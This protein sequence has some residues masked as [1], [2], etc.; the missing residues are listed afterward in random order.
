L[1]ARVGEIIMNFEINGKGAPATLISGIASDISTWSMQA[2][3]FA[4][5]FLTIRF[6]NRG[7]GKTEAPD[8]PYTIEVMANDTSKLLDVIGIECSNLIGFGMGGRIALEMAIKHPTKVKTLVLC[9]CAP[10]ATPFERDLYNLMRSGIADGIGRMALARHD[11]EWTL[12]PRFLEDKRVAEA[13]TRVRMYKMS[14]TTDQ[15][16]MRQ[17]EA[18]LDYDATARLGEVKCP[19]L[20]IAGKRDRLVPPEYQRK[21]AD[22]IPEASFLALDT[23]HMVLTEAAKDFNKNAMGFLIE[24]GA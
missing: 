22:A 24:N 19:T 16:L 9:S 11:V 1:I 17:T 20:V 10:K 8:R 14:N 4:L 7:A 12:N 2:S 18:V 23:A 5:N 15:D 3:S 6:D 21:M 13:I